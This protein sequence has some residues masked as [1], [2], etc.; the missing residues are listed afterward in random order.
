MLLAAERSGSLVDALFNDRRR[1]R[2]KAGKLI[3][4]NFRDASQNGGPFSFYSFVL[5]ACGGRRSFRKR[6][7]AEADDVID[8]FLRLALEHEQKQAPSLLRFIDNFISNDF[9]VKRDMDSGRNQIRVMTVHGAK[10]LEAP[11]VYMPDTFGNAVEK[12][13]VDP[14][15]NISP[16]PN[17]YIPIWSPSQA[18]DSDMIAKLREEAFNK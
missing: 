13:K 16:D 2:F 1:D 8:E 3:F 18:T 12:Q 6:F 4:Q 7:G 15:F 11:I 9:S 17:E 5:C 14:I 10:G